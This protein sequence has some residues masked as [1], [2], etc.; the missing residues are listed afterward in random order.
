MN[1]LIMHYIDEA[2]SSEKYMIDLFLKKRFESISE[3]EIFYWITKIQKKGILEKTVN[4]LYD[5]I[6]KSI[7]ISEKSG[8]EFNQITKFIIKNTLLR[9]SNKLL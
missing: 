9:I 2:S 7:R 3:E 8:K 5:V 1:A 4:Y 6:T